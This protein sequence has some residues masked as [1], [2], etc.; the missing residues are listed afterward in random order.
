[1][2]HLGANS[3]TKLIETTI[4]FVGVVGV[5]GVVFVWGAMIAASIAII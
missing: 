5:V 1:M 3:M 4:K 2:Q